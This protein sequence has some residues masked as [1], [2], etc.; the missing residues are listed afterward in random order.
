MIP[1]KGK[2]TG[3]A[4]TSSALNQ[5]PSLFQQAGIGAMTECLELYSEILRKE[6]MEG[7]YPDEI[8]S[9]SGSFRRTFRRGQPQ[10]IFQVTARGSTITGTFGSEDQRARILN[11][12]GVIYPR[13]GPFLAVRSSFTKTAGGVVQ[14]KY[15]QPL[16]QLPNTFVRRIHHRRGTAEAAVFEKRGRLIVPIAWLVRQVYIKGRQFMAKTLTKA[17]PRMPA[18]FERRFHMISEQMQKMLARFK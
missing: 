2:I 7:P 16:R 8:Q 15:Q 13:R 12:G 1:I 10:N 14:A 5:L 6:H 17:A 9:R 18:I 11:E 3:L 4:E